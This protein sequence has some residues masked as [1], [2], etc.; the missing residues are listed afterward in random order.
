MFLQTNVGK[1]FLSW[2]GPRAHLVVTDVDLIKDI[3]NDKDGAFP[4][5]KPQGFAKKLLGDGII[6]ARGEKWFKLRKISNHAFH[7]ESLKVY[8]YIYAS[9][10]FFF[11]L[12]Y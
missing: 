12:F 9:L 10:V 8:T 3:F 6:T 5:G 2:H 4:K 7:A 1:N 11:F